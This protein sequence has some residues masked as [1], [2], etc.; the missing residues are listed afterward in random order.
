MQ[1]VHRLE[2]LLLGL[3]AAAL[4]IYLAA[5]AL[6]VACAIIVLEAP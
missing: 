4:V 3:F 1:W 5:I 6:A 2:P